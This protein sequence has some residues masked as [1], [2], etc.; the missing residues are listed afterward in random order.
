MASIGVRLTWR[1]CS[2]E[3]STQKDSRKKRT[4]NR[5]CVT[6]VTGLLLAVLACFVAIFT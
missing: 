2:G 6:N 1:D 3:L 5:F 4:A